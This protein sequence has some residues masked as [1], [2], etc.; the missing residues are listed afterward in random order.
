MGYLN[1]NSLG[2]ITATVTTTMEDLQD[3]APRVMD[4]MLHGY[5]HAAVITLMLVWWVSC[6]LSA[7]TP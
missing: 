2:A 4:K 3:V 7:S 5:I 6:S 1:D